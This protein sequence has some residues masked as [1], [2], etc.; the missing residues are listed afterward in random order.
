MKQ[1]SLFK[2][3]REERRVTNT[4]K[5]NKLVQIL[6]ER[7]KGELDQEQAVSKVGHFVIVFFLF[8]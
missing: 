1:H 8:F 7:C 4:K 6:S 3:G 2:K 5:S